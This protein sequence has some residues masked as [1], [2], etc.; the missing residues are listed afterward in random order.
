MKLKDFVNLKKNSSNNQI[1]LDIQKKKIKALG[2]S[3]D[4]ILNMKI[5]KEKIKWEEWIK[6]NLFF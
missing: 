6:I 3:T 1:S 2:M 4:D 5:Q